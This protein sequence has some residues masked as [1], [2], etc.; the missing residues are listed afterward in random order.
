MG[1]WT[2]LYRCRAARRSGARTG[3]DPT[4]QKNK[5]DQIHGSKRGCL[6]GCPTEGLDGVDLMADRMNTYQIYGSKSWCRTE[7]PDEVTGGKIYG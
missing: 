5:A 2:A 4:A 6:T 3:I 1:E 7:G